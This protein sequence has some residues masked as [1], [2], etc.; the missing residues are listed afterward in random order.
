MTWQSLILISRPR[1]WLYLAG[2]YLIG[3]VAGITDPFDLNT[4]LFWLYF[5]YLLFPANFFLYG[6]NDLA[7]EDTDQHNP[8]KN[9]QENRLKK[10]QRSIVKMGLLLHSLLTVILI[11]NLSS[12]LPKLL[13]AILWSLS[14]AYSHQPFRWKAFP[15]ID[16]LSNFLYVLPGLLGYA[17]TTGH[18]PSFWLLLAS[19]SWA[20]AMHLFSAIPDIMAD[21][22]AQLQ[23]SAIFF[24]K[25]T[26]LLLCSFLWL[27]SAGLL[28]LISHS[29]WML[30][31][32]IYPLLPLLILIK[33]VKIEK[34]Y[35]AFP[36]LTS[37][38]GL[39]LFW[40]IFINRFFI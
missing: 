17:L 31:F 5:L 13:L 38:L 22:K 28:L 40:Y 35:W 25:S 8:K 33:R 30:P 12:V 3:Y 2:P 11:A 19:G 20:T 21:K 29:I 32:F 18:L 1:F 9:N 15:I 14:F 26:S 34:L 27:L 10:S 4:P 6:I 16:S 24:G 39:Y 36:Y 23:T 37:F 7:D